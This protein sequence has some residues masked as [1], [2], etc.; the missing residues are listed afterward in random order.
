[1]IDFKKVNVKKI[2]GPLNLLICIYWYSDM[3]TRLE[4]EI[5]K[6]GALLCLGC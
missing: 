6:A 4:E 1:M 2:F 3:D 5:K